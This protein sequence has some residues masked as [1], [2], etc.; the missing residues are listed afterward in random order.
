M[1]ADE[2]PLDSATQWVADHTRRYVETDGAEGH[3][4]RGVPTLVLERSA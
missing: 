3:L 4:W 1:P 2:E